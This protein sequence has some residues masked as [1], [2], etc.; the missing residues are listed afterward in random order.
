MT[1]LVYITHMELLDFALLYI[2]MKNVCPL[3]VA[4]YDKVHGTAGGGARLCGIFM[5]LQKAVVGFCLCV[6]TLYSL[7]RGALKALV[8]QDKSCFLIYF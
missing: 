8:S 4:G 1:A 3:L 2:E 6:Y 7:S 5:R